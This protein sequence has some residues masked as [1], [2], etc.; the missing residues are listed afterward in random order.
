M[1]KYIGKRILVSVVTLFLIILILFLLMEWLPGSPFNDEKL[2]ELQKLLLTQK[3]GLDKPFLTRFGIYLNNLVHGDFGISYVIAVDMPVTRLLS[4]RLPVTIRIGLQAMAVGVT[5]GLV[6]G[7]VAAIKKN[8]WIDTAA[9]VLSVL[10]FSVPSYVFALFLV[11]F[12]AFKLQWFPILFSNGKPFQS[13][14]LPTISLSVYIIATMA[15]YARS[16]MIDCLNSDYIILAKAKGIAQK[17]IIIRHAL[18]NTLVPIITVISPLMIGLITGSVVV[19]QI[20][21]V[22]GLGQLLLS[23]IQND[24]YNVIAA[25]AVIYS[26][27]YIFIMLVVDIL[28]GLIDPRIRLAGESA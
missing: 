22:P 4:S 20:F 19:E 14:V 23:G 2:D 9:T 12:I 11:F 15:R 16:E 21:G 25:V 8:S 18:R 10:G 5:I 26:C 27:L 3:Y 1:K 13:S 24:D 28:Y 17:N 7:I 6:L